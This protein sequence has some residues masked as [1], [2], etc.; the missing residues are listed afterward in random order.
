[1]LGFNGVVDLR[2][3]LVQS[4]L[5]SLQLLAYRIVLAFENLSRAREVRYDDFP[6]F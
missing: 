2:R 1:M 6:I 5:H 4:L 3:R